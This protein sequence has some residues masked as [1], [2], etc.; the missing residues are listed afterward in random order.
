MIKLNINGKEV[1]ATDGMTVLEAAEAA[2]IFIPTLCRHS[3]LTPYGGCRLCMVEIKGMKRYPTACTTPVE[4]DMVVRTDTDKIQELRRR[5][6]E[7][8]LSEHPYICL[9]CEQKDKCEEYQ[10]SIRKVGVTT[11][12]KFCPND[13]QCELQEVVE[14]IGIKDVDFPINYRALSVEKFDPFYDRDYNLCILCGRCV[15]VCQEV[16]DNGVLAFT[17]RGPRALVG[18]AFGKSHIESGCEFCGACVDVCPTGALYENRVKWEGK[19]DHYVATVCPYCGIGCGINLNIK[20]NKIISVTPA[21][22]GKANNGQACVRGRFC[23]AQIVHSNNRIKVPMI[24]K[25]EKLVEVSW[26]EAL[27][28]IASNLSKYKGEQ[29]ACIACPQCTNEDIYMFQKFTRKIMN[30]NNI[31]IAHQ[32]EENAKTCECNLV[33]AYSIIFENGGKLGTNPVASI[34]HRYEEILKAVEAGKIKALYV[35]GN[36]AKVPVNKLEYL[37]VQSV[38]PTPEVAVADVVLPVASF[39]EVDGSFT[40]MNGKIQQL[41]RAIGPRYDSQSDWWVVCEVA[42]RMGGQGFEVKGAQEIRDEIDRCGINC[43][44]S[45]QEVSECFQRDIT[46]LEIKPTDGLY[47]YR[48]GELVDEVKGLREIVDHWRK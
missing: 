33:G 17:Y 25:G 2:G 19:P 27:N 41:Q 39:A 44:T 10:Y 1:Q 18:T 22:E 8:I 42:K 9:I 46:V 15:R 7:L 30:S 38:F 31:A 20:E 12:C 48:G 36:G 14:H 32:V 29:F 3:N 26:D 21:S 13:E 4:P 45:A 40:S 47:H 34:R 16:R 37:I 11:G 6:L 23:V 35:T 24:R 28:T 43:T 5:I